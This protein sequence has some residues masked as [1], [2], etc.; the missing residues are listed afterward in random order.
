VREKADERGCG[1]KRVKPRCWTI[2]SHGAALGFAFRR[3]FIGDPRCRSRCPPFV[4]PSL[5]GTV[6]QHGN[7][8]LVRDWMKNMSAIL[9]EWDIMLAPAY[10]DLFYIPTNV[11]FLYNINLFIFILTL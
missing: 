10:Q 8:P 9:V 7:E 5:L 2:Q 6:G 1:R 3:V 4:F 11:N